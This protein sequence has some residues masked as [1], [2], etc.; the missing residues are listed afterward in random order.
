MDLFTNYEKKC[1]ELTFEI[2]SYNTKWQN[3]LNRLKAVAEE[4]CRKY[5]DEIP[6]INI[7]RVQMRNEIK[8]LYRFL[9]NFGDIGEKITVFDFVTEETQGVKDFYNNDVVKRGYA[10]A[11]TIFNAGHLIGGAATLAIGSLCTFNPVFAP[12][13]VGLGIHKRGKT[14]EDYEKLLFEYES[15][16]EA[17]KKNLEKA[18]DL[19]KFFETAYE[20]AVIYRNIIVTVRDSIS[21]TII[22]ELGGIKAF[23]YAD[24]V[25]QKIDNGEHL[26][27]IVLPTDIREFENT[28]YNEHF[29]FIKNTCDYYNLIVALFKEQILTNIVKDGHVSKAERKAFNEKI[30]CIKNE[31]NKLESTT[32]F[33]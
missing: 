17:N 10:K 4:V 5:N 20:I 7:E 3:E 6:I 23:L 8:L 25:A 24:A 19:I 30:I 14:K 15:A 21:E 27:G 12:M 33:K 31:K 13:I 18:K 32:V 22:P 16:K 26:Q 11:T 28:R 29:L 2:E 9:K 1:E